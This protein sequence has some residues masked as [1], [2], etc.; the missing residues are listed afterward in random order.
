MV[1]TAYVDNEQRDHTWL[2]TFKSHVDESELIWHMD[3]HTR[4]VTVLEGENWQLQL[5]NQLPHS[6]EPGETYVIP[7]VH[8]HRLIRGS[9]NLVIKISECVS[10]HPG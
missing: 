4:H 8:Y 6:L 1:D 2:R 7:A 5:D 10:T 3:H 9:S